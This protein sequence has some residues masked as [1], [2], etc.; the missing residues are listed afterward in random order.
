MINDSPKAKSDSSA[1]KVQVHLYYQGTSGELPLFLALQRTRAKG[2][3]WQPV[4]GKVEPNEALIEAALREV[5]EETGLKAT[6]VP[7]KVG[8]I[9]F[10]K[11]GRSIHETIFVLESPGQEVQLSDEHENY[12]WLLF[13]EA[14][15]LFHYD[16][17]RFGL[18]LAAE[19][20]Q[21]HDE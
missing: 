18:K 3:I 12:S 5:E 7:V 10:S 11:E 16:S 14:I 6:S 2:N 8:E 20:I 17:N 15:T 21:K 9:T 4:T 13:D 19:R 1:L